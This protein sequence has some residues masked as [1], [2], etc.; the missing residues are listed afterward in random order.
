M[1]KLNREFTRDEISVLLYFETCAVD[2]RGLFEAKHVSSADLLLANK[3]QGEG[4]IAYGRIPAKVILKWGKSHP[5]L[6][7][8]HWVRLGDDVW[9]IVHRERRAKAER[10]IS[11]LAESACGGKKSVGTQN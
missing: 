3:L 11:D 1:L 5:V 8:T 9:K 10:T 7:E 2:S 4:F 6:R